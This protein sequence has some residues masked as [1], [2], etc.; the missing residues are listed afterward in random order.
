MYFFFCDKMHWPTKFQTFSKMDLDLLRFAKELFI[1]L[2]NAIRK[3]LPM[4]WPSIES[5]APMS[6]SIP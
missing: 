5:I 2:F 1:S 4:S 3:H 6:Y